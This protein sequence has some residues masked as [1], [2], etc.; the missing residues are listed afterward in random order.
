[1][2]FIVSDEAEE[3]LVNLFAKYNLAQVKMDS[4]YMWRVYFWLLYFFGK[5]SIIV[6]KYKEYFLRRFIRH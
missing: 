2:E 3:Q 4:E 5:E 6:G 1:M